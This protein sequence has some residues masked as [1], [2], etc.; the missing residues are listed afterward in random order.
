MESS[1]FNNEM[2]NPNSAPRSLVLGSKIFA[3]AVTFLLSIFFHSLIHELGHLVFGLFNNYEFIS[4]TLFGLTIYRE[5]NNIKVRYDGWTNAMGALIMA[6]KIKASTKNNILYYLGG[7]IFNLISLVFLVLFFIFDPAN[8]LYIGIAIFVGITLL[9]TNLIPKEIKGLY[10]DGY[11]VKMYMSDKDS[12]S[13]SQVF[14]NYQREL[15]AGTRPRDLELLDQTFQDDTLGVF[16]NLLMYYKGLDQ[17]DISLM[18][19]RMALVKSSYGILENVQRRSIDYELLFY[20]LMVEEDRAEAARAFSEV[21]R[22]LERDM[23]INGRR[24]LSYYQFYGLLNKEAAYKT[25]LEGLEAYD[26][27]P[28]RGLAKMERSLLEKLI[29]QVQD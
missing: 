17:W 13:F 26:H 3:G 18:K 4:L 6:P 19:S 16:I 24:V 10:N 21:E 12:T 23:D 8:R 27:Y 25:A 20:H 2:T 9:L 7:S 22:H 1:F 11:L 5:N 14:Q 15:I 28:F 29:D